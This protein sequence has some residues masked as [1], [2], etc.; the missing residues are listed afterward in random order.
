[1]GGATL[2]GRDR[3]TI[4]AINAVAYHRGHHPLPKPGERWQVYGRTVVVAIPKRQWG[5]AAKANPRKRAH[6]VSRVYIA[7]LKG[8]YLGAMVRWKCGSHSTEFVLEDEPYAQ[9]TPCQMCLLREP[10]GVVNINVVVEKG[11]RLRI[12]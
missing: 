3:E 2:W 7:W 10:G 5:H 11:G 12:G 8:H 9:A 4:W 6:L 1:M